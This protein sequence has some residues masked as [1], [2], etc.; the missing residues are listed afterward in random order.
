VELSLNLAGISLYGSVRV[1]KA[2]FNCVVRDKVVPLLDVVG[3]FCSGGVAKSRRKPLDLAIQWEQ[4]STSAGRWTNNTLRG[5]YLGRFAQVNIFDGL[6]PVLAGRIL[7][8]IL[9]G[10]GSPVVHA[11][12][13]KARDPL[14]GVFEV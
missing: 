13:K 5:D 10:G 7:T 14:A 11:V 9:V 3:R 2:L 4:G 8:A 1:A 12:V 6:I